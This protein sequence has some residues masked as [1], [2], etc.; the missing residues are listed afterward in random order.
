LLKT[1]PR[2]RISINIIDAHHALGAR[3]SRGVVDDDVRGPL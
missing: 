1:Y 2:V 3:T